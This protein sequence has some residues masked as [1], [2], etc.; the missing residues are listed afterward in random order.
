MKKRCILVI[1]CMMILGTGCSDS[2]RQEETLAENEQKLEKEV[3]EEREQE[4]T[5]RE[6]ELTTT[7]EKTVDYSEYFQE[8]SGCAVLYDESENTYSFYNKEQCEKEFSPL[9]TF[10]I[11]STLAG[12]EYG[13]LDDEKATME[14]SGVKYPIDAWNAEL[15]LEDAFQTSCV[16]YF[17]Q[18][19]DCVGQDNVLSLLNELQ[20]GNCDISEWNG[21]NVNPLPELNGF[22]LDASLKISPLQQTY[23]LNYLFSLK[24][25][26]NDKNLEIL[27]EV[28]YVTGLE[29]G[30]LYGKTGT[31]TDEAWFVGFIERNG[32]K[33]YFAVYLE[34]TQNKGT[35]SGDKAREIVIS[36]LQG[37]V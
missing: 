26:F 3:K 15:T 12:L 27:K 21:A 8:I 17:R 5:G 18:V 6:N 33:T 24:N 37:E 30:V 14:Y 19:V 13:I 23:V 22:W 28:M 11:V 25:S 32:N 4:E 36:L 20:Y 16:W 1:L 7:V 29:D 31:G 10:K 35:V 2:E 9:S 34:D